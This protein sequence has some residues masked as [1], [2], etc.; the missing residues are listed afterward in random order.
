MP[1]YQ[2]E[3]SHFQELITGGQY[4]EPSRLIEGDPYYFSRQFEKGSLSINGITYPEVSLLYDIYRD[5]V[6]TFQPVFNQ[7]IL[8]K[9]EKIDGFVLGNGDRFRH[10]IG[11]ES[12]G[13][14]GNGVYQVLGEGEFL[15]LA[16][17]TKSTKPKR[18][19]SKYDSEYVMKVDFFLWKNGEFFPI[20]KPNQAF[21]ILGLEKKKIKKEL[22]ANQLNFKQGPESFLKFLVQTPR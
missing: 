22:K 6:V 11:N 15:A 1:A 17:R 21:E 3:F 19:L 20:Q 7:K 12:Y 4:A 16:K 9:P 5:Q 10:F 13:K 8:I 14:N 18:E 2:A